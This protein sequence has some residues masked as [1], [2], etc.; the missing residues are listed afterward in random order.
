MLPLLFIN[1]E[2]KTTDESS[3]NSSRTTDVGVN[4]EKGS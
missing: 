4:L 3:S 2:E 1:T